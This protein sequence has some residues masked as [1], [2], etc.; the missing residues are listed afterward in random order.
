MVVDRLLLAP[1]RAM[2]QCQVV[3]DQGRE[4]S[5]TGCAEAGRGEVVGGEGLGCRAVAASARRPASS[6]LP[7]LSTRSVAMLPRGVTVPEGA[8]ATLSI[9]IPQAL[10][11]VLHL[12]PLNSPLPFQHRRPRRTLSQRLDPVRLLA[13]QVL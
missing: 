3:E 2:D 12:R 4:V 1:L 11:H 9:H 7:C 8:R 6:A 10:Q 13:R 5:I